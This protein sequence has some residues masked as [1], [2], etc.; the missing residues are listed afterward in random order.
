M[1][2]NNF[3]LQRSLFALASTVVMGTTT[4]APVNAATFNFNEKNNFSKAIKDIQFELVRG[5]TITLINN[6]VFTTQMISTDKKSAIL[7]GANVAPGGQVFFSVTTQSMPTKIKV[8]SVSFT[9]GTFKSAPE[10]ASVLSLLGVG[11]FAATRVL[12]KKREA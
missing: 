1:N 8:T 7:D 5:G 11:L 4:I 9:D 6:G 3:T 2:N 12:K 10:P